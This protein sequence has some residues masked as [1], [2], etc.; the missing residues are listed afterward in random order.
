MPR[1]AAA[2][3]DLP[4]RA[5]RAAGRRAAGAGG[6]SRPCRGTRFATPL[7]SPCSPDGRGTP[8]PGSRSPSRRRRADRRGRAVLPLW[9]PSSRPRASTLPASRP[10]PA[11][12]GREARGG[13]SP[14]SAPLPSSR[15]GRTPRRPGAKGSRCHAGAEGRVRWKRTPRD[16]GRSGS[17]AAERGCADCSAPS[18]RLPGVSCR[19]PRGS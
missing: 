5:G 13:R 11:S 10:R 12:D 7:A 17:G 6:N 15:R 19:Y 4:Q 9:Q 1:A 2:A 3:R 18:R 8:H 16:G 14:R